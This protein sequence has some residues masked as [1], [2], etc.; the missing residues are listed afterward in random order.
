VVGTANPCNIFW[1]VG[2]SA[3][4]NGTNFR[5][6]VIATTSITVGSGANIAGRALAGVGAS[7]VVTMAGSGGNTIGYTRRSKPSTPASTSDAMTTLTEA[8]E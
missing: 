7:G 6:A 2:S 5:G 4:L 3:T 8:A 1:R